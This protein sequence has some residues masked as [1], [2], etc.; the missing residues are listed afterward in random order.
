MHIF[1]TGGAG[2]IG[3][4]LVEKLLDH[5]HS[6]QAIDNFDPFYSRG[7]KERNLKSASEHPNFQ[8]IETDILNRQGLSEIF[9]SSNFDIVVHLAAKAGVRPSLEDPSG[10]YQVNVQGTLNI[11]DMCKNYKVKKLIFASSSSVYG[12]NKKV[13]FSE[14]DS[15]DFPISP[16]AATKKAGELLCH[17]YHHLYGINI[18]ALRF[19]TVYGPRQR[20]DL[21]I[22]K[23][24]HKIYNN[25]KI[26][27]FGDG[28]TA[29]DYTYIEDILEGIISCVELIKGY[30]IINLGE[31]VPI[32]LMDLISKIESISGK[33]ADKGFSPMQPGDVKQTH[34]DISKA[35]RLLDYD[36]QT[37][38]DKG[39]TKFKEWF[40][41]Q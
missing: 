37:D 9:N 26:S 36:P 28:S 15:V 24:F 18:F 33:T 20:P 27:L 5:G 13:P 22:H 7:V 41:S 29:R 40:E 32:S 34:A 6:V 17:T 38:L 30:E 23:F 25:E 39:L 3:S 14:S 31:S 1:V 8:L 10:Y 2:F 4:H 19:F 12:N 21:A 16:Y 11:L 35:K